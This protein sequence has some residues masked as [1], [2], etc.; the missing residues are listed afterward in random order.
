M[1][2]CELIKEGHTFGLLAVI[3]A[4]RHDSLLFKSDLKLCFPVAAKSCTSVFVV[5]M[6]LAPCCCESVQSVSG[7]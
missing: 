5:T 2:E 3:V 7:M 1:K 4:V 6:D